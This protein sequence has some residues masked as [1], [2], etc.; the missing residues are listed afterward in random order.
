MDAAGFQ[1]ICVSRKKSAPK[2]II[3]TTKRECVCENPLR[4]KLDG[5]REK[6]VSRWCFAKR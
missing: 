2:I 3:K 1:D 4:K 6:V 5:R